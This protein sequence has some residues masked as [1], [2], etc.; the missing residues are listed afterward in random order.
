MEGTRILM[1]RALCRLNHQHLILLQ[2]K[3][4]GGCCVDSSEESI[5][6]R[7]YSVHSLAC[8]CLQ[9]VGASTTLIVTV[10]GFF[11]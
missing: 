3:G 10:G 5:E 8:A 9:V 11:C 6:A 1:W 2:E 7:R 4:G